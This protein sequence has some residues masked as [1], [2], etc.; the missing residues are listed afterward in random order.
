MVTATHEGGE[1]EF[2]SSSSLI[3]LDSFLVFV[4]STGDC[5]K[6]FPNVFATGKF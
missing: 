1:F 4:C 6:M 5:N 3:G 2:G